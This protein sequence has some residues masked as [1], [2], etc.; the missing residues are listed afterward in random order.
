MPRNKRIAP[1]PNIIGGFIEAGEIIDIVQIDERTESYGKGAY[2]RVRRLKNFNKALNLFAD[3][4]FWGTK[5][6]KLKKLVHDP[7]KTSA[8]ADVLVSLGVELE[9]RALR[10]L[11][12]EIKKQIK[13]LDN[14]LSKT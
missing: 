12:I 8:L 6:R 7:R 4:Y 11:A 2:L 9:D 5:K 3:E 1:P 13:A 10:N 14:A